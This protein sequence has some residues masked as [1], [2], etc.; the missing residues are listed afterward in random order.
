MLTR[1]SHPQWVT[2]DWNVTTGDRA[3][4]GT[5]PQGLCVFRGASHSHPRQDLTAPPQPH[6]SLGRSDAGGAVCDSRVHLRHLTRG[7]RN[8]CLVQQG[9]AGGAVAL[10]DQTHALT[11]PRHGRQVG[12]VERLADRDALGKGGLRALGVSAPHLCVGIPGE[13][14]RTFGTVPTALKYEG[15]VRAIPSQGPS[16]LGTSD[17]PRP[18]E[19]SGRHA[20]GRCTGWLHGEHASR[21]ARIPLPSPSC[22]RRTPASQDHPGRAAQR[23]QTSRT[24]VGVAPRAVGE[25]RP[26]LPEYADP[27]HRSIV[28]CLGDRLLRGA[29]T[30]S[31]GALGR[32]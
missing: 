7:D 1:A 17:P 15:H 9:H 24:S 3:S 16:R 32:R 13:E 26:R 14:P 29:V 25:G 11:E 31:A 2:Q 27:R 23:H 12:V 20:A 18:E 28:R 6:P 5:A 19:R 22:R 21:P 8:P 10:H 30:D 4:H